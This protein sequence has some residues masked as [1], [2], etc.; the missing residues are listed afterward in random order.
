MTSLA[1]KPVLERL[2][3]IEATLDLSNVNDTDHEARLRALE[4]DSSPG[5]Q[6]DHEERIRRLERSW[7]RMAGAAAAVGG[8]LGA[9][10]GPAIGAITS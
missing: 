8:I 2:A 1:T 6:A 7:W 10:V 3:R 9:V 5:Q 4:Q